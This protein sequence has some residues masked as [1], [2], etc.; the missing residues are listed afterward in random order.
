[1]SKIDELGGIEGD[2]SAEALKSL[3]EAPMRLRR[4][5]LEETKTDNSETIDIS[6]SDQEALHAFLTSKGESGELYLL[7]KI[8][9][10]QGNHSLEVKPVRLVFLPHQPKNSETLTPNQRAKRFLEWVQQER[11]S[12][13]SM[14]DEQLRRENLYE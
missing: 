6:L 3:L 2:L 13:P 5:D 4:S 1:M 12:A 7:S 8:E 10:S 14:T 11:P 9:K